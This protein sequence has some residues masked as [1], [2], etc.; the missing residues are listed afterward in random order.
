MSTQT[1]EKIYKEVKALKEETKT[2]KEL[3]FLI[4]KDVAAPTYYLKGKAAKE[5]DKLVKEGIKEYK[6]GK[7]IRASSLKEAL[8]IYGRK[9]Y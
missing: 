7:T 1:A 8:K 6:T 4:L 5:A 3:V 9:K 2:L